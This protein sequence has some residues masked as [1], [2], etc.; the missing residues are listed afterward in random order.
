MPVRNPDIVR[1]RLKALRDTPGLTWRQIAAEGE[2]AGIP[3]GT[4]CAIAGGAPIPQRHR[5]RLGLPPLGAR[6]VPVAGFIPEGALAFE[7]RRCVCG[8]YFV[9]NHWRRKYCFA[10]SPYKG[11]KNGSVV[12]SEEA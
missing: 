9:P 6:I 2:F 7:A 12:G 11:R 1:A 3:P 8:Q 5:A 4:L 10:C